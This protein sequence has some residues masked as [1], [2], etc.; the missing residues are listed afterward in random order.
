[1]SC[2]LSL[3]CRGG[4]VDRH[5]PACGRDDRGAGRAHLSCWTCRGGR[6]DRRH[7]A[8]GRDD[9]GAGRFSYL[10]WSFSSIHGYEEHASMGSGSAAGSVQSIRRCCQTNANRSPLL[11]PRPSIRLRVG[12]ATRRGRRHGSACRCYGSGGGAPNRY[13]SQEKLALRV[14]LLAHL[15]AQ[16][17]RTL[18]RNP[19]DLINQ[20]FGTESGLIVRFCAAIR[21]GAFAA[22]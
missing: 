12:R 4:R 21:N 5:H 8:C 1:M 13:L 11:L 22:P 17:A 2:R 9:R 19:T 20:A 18:D 10:T 6:A 3:K 15:S 7:P 14:P 16:E